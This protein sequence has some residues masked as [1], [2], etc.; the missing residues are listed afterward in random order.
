M[1]K[2]VSIKGYGGQADKKGRIERREKEGLKGMWKSVGRK[3][4]WQK[5][6]ESLLFRNECNAVTDIRNHI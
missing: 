1:H 2:S 4:D 5:L 6:A 3:G